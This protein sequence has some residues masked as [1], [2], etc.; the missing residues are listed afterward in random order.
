MSISAIRVKY[1]SLA[2]LLKCSTR[3]KHYFNR[4]FVENFHFCRWIICQIDYRLHWTYSCIFICPL[5]YSCCDFL[6]TSPVNKNS[7]LAFTCIVSKLILLH[8]VCDCSDCIYRQSSVDFCIVAE[9]RSV[10]LAQRNTINLILPCI[11][12]K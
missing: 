5:V 6:Y 9:R 10:K 8:P 7:V 2:N 1:L 11:V 12:Q 3:F 4:N